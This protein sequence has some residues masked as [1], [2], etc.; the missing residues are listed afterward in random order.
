MHVL[1]VPRSYPNKLNPVSGIFFQQQVTELEKEFSVG[2]LAYLNL[3]LKQ[4]FSK[5][6]WKTGPSWNKNK[7]LYFSVAVPFL[8]ALSMWLR[9]VILKRKFRVYIKKCGRPDLVHVHCAEAGAVALWIKK[10]YGIPY[11]VTEHLSRM[12]KANLPAYYTSVVK[13]VYEEAESRIAV[14]SGFAEVLENHFNLP[15]RVIPNM[16]DCDF[17]SLKEKST[18]EKSINTIQV[19]GLNKNK[20]HGA[21]IRAVKMMLDKGYNLYHTIIGDGEERKT[22][23]KLISDLK[24]NDHVHL[25]G[26]G[27]RAQVRDALHKADFFISSSHKETFGVVMIE[28]M[29]CGLPVLSTKTNG[30]MDLIHEGENAYLCEPDSKSL[31]DGMVKMLQ[32]HWNPGEIRENVLKNFSAEVVIGELKREYK[33]IVGNGLDD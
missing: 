18:D 11:L 20:N 28:A 31:C 21:V 3:S 29:C 25:A 13:A 1:I 19:G 16:V 22:L 6:F 27:S 33:K 15:F 30:A 8:K 9:L 14:S 12:Y 7:M 5:R 24:I 23:E 17:F 10:N 4:R 2:V 32:N 26:Q